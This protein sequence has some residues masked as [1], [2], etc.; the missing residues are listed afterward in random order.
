MRASVRLVPRLLTLLRACPACYAK[1][2][3]RLRAKRLSRAENHA[4]ESRMVGRI[5]KMLRL[6]GDGRAVRI[7]AIVFSVNRPVEKVTGIELK[8]GLRGANVE[9]AATRRLV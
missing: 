7:E 2:K 5:G 6:E 9:C 8:P 3:D 4:R 1:R